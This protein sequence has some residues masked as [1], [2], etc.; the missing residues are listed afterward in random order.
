MEIDTSMSLDEPLDSN[1]LSLWQLITYCWVIPILLSPGLSDYRI[2]LKR[3][4]VTKIDFYLFI[5]K[6][7]YHLVQANP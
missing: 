2:I 6:I 7:R 3:V 1:R 5:F 4:N